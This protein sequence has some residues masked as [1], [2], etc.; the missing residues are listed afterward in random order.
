MP[1]PPIGFFQPSELFPL[2]SAVTSEDARYSLGVE[3][4]KRM[5]KEHSHALSPETT[6]CQPSRRNPRSA[7]ST[8]PLKPDIIL[9]ASGKER[10]KEFRE[11]LMHP[12][13]KEDLHLLG[14]FWEETCDSE[15]PHLQ[16]FAPNGESV[17]PPRVLPRD[18]ADTLMA[19]FPRER[20]WC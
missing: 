20:G 11:E 3:S 14:R 6:L 16:S 10:G 4:A 13:W 5:S 8:S 17:H 1:H 7:K 19:F 9:P 12:L 18:G 2:R 15:D